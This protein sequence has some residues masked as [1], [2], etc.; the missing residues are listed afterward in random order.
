VSEA[1]RCRPDVVVMDLRF[2]D[3]SGVEACRDIRS[4]FPDVRVL[5]LT[6]YDDQEAVV[7]SILA[8]AAGYLLKQTDPEHLIEAVR[9]VARGGTLLDNSAIQAALEWMRSQAASVTQDDPLAVLSDQER[10]ILPLVAQGK[11]NRE[12]AVELRLSESTVKT[13]V[14]YMLQKLHMARRAEMAAF[15]IRQA[16]DSSK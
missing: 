9:V 16:S 1:R 5:M 4:E 10:R 14:S 8:G 12:I 6:S 11:T 3:G 15:A 2:P 7:G 13:Y